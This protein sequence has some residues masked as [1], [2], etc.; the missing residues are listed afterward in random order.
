MTQ[1]QAPIMHHLFYNYHNGT[2]QNKEVRKFVFSFSF[3]LMKNKQIIDK[4]H[5][6]LHFFRSYQQRNKRNIK[7][8]NFH[9]ILNKNTL[10]GE[11]FIMIFRKLRLNA[12]KNHRENFPPK[13]DF[14]LFIP[15]YPP[16]FN[17]YCRIVFYIISI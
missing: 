6:Q 9:T 17:Q 10:R 14:I 11:I 5:L 1:F 15:S 8:I 16:F 2:F 12:K 7:T 4:I 13:C 3:Q